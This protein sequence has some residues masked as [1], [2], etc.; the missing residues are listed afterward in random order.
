MP[1]DCTLCQG[2]MLKLLCLVFLLSAGGC[3]LPPP[4]AVSPRAKID[5]L[6]ISV[7][8]ARASA[9]FYQGLFGFA[10]LKTPFVGGGGVVWLA[11]GNGAAL[12]IFG[13]RVLALANERERH[14][15][16]TVADMSKVTGFLVARGIPWQDFDGTAGEM[17]TR[18][19]GVRQMFFR[20]P[21]GYWIEVNDALKD[22]AF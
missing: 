17:Q 9:A 3:A 1:A 14:L 11:I 13:G 2:H 19:D 8:D 21:D 5:H 22:G 12:H 15:A 20:D 4:A 18:P 16:I 7:A 10:E 6:A